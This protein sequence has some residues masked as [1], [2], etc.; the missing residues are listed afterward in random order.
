MKIK[1]TQKFVIEIFGAL[2]IVDFQSFQ[3]FKLLR[4]SPT[5]AKGEGV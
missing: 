2:K 3:V 4:S 5:L 1:D